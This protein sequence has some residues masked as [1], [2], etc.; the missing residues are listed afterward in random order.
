MFLQDSNR[1]HFCRRYSIARNMLHSDSMRTLFQSFMP[2]CMRRWREKYS[3]KFRFFHFRMWS[4]SW[5]VN[6]FLFQVLNFESIYLYV[7]KHETSIILCIFEENPRIQRIKQINFISGDVG[8]IKMSLIIASKY[9]DVRFIHTTRESRSVWLK[10]CLCLIEKKRFIE[11]NVDDRFCKNLLLWQ[12][13]FNNM[14][15]RR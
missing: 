8:N 7:Q 5:T 11:W 3:Q 12:Q 9:R 6:A 10:R 15:Y 13:S 1:S 4:W 14:K 2:N